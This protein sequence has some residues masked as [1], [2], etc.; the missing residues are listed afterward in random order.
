[1][2][3]A[4]NFIT[5]CV[6]HSSQPFKQKVSLSRIKTEDSKMS[7]LWLHIILLHYIIVLFGEQSMTLHTNECF[8]DNSKPEAGTCSLEE[9]AN[10]KG[11]RSFFS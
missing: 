11:N 6:F 7:S 5:L 10:N 1:M 8:A 9:G 4:V 2:P 3:M